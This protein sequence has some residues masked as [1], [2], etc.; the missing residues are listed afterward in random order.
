MAEM[1]SV[2]V[3]TAMMGITDS[4]GLGTDSTDMQVQSAPQVEM[5]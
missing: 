5:N 4:S 1:M 2:P 3:P